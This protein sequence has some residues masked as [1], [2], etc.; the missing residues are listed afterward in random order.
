VSSRNNLSNEDRN[1]PPSNNGFPEL[2]HEEELEYEDMAQNSTAHGQ[3]GVIAPFVLNKQY[4]RPYL[5]WNERFKE[6]VSFKT[7]YGHTKVPRKYGPLGTWIYVQQTQYCLLKEGKD[8]RL[9]MDEYEK[10]ESIGFEFKYRATGMCPS[11]NQRF[12]ELVEFKK[13]NGHTNVPTRS[14]P[15]GRWIV[16]QRMQLGFLKEGNR[17]PLTIER[18]EKME[19]IGFAASSYNESWNQRFQ[20]LVDFKKTNGHTNVNTQSGGPLGR[21]VAKQRTDYRLLKEGKPSSLTTSLTTMD[22]RE[23]L[24][25]IGFTFSLKKHR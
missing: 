24:E 13:I 16:R 10:L 15:L 6:L 18:R 22:R 9:T 23:K 1:D 21:W 14:G 4:K 5:S 25:S 20:E 17:S 11:W 3:A 7:I 2:P 19:S 8:S 12:Q